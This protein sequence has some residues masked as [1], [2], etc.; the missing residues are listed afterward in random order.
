MLT[1]NM[2]VGSKTIPFLTVGTP[3]KIFLFYP[4]LSPVMEHKELM[5]ENC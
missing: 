2:I 1:F 3:L 5:K 4:S